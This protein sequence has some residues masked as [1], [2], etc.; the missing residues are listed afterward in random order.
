MPAGMEGDNKRQRSRQRRVIERRKDELH[1]YRKLLEVP[2]LTVCVIT[3]SYCVKKCE[4]RP[5][6]IRSFVCFKC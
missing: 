6:P 5:N 4:M 2:Q 3:V 1:S